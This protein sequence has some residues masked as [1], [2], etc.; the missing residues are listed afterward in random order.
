MWR[1]WLNYYLVSYC[2]CIFWL[3]KVKRTYFYTKNCPNYSFLANHTVQLGGE[4]RGREEPRKRQRTVPKFTDEWAQK[5]DRTWPGK[6]RGDRGSREGKI[7]DWTVLE[8]LYSQFRC[9]SHRYG[10]NVLGTDVLFSNGYPLFL[11]VCPKDEMMHW[12]RHWWAPR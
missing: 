2:V 9:F 10:A 6:G 3:L 11:C 7:T 4:N 5:P 12:D 1:F 8:G